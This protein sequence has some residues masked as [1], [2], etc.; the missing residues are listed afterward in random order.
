MN[1]PVPFEK[2]SLGFWIVVGIAVVVTLGVAFVLVK[3]TNR[4]K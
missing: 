2:N 1:V 4:L 3:R